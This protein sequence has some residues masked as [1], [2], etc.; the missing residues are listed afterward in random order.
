[1][2]VFGF[3]GVLTVLAIPVA[4]L[5]FAVLA[6]KEKAARRHHSTTYRSKP[7]FSEEDTA[8]YIRMR[9]VMNPKAYK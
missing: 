4:I 5:V 7:I 1:M 6:V 3:M 2:F 9:G 8:A